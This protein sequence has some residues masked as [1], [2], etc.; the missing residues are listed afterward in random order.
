MLKLDLRRWFGKCMISESREIKM[1]FDPLT[2]CPAGAFICLA[3][4]A[5]ADKIFAAAGGDQAV[6]WQYDICPSSCP[7]WFRP[8]GWGAHDLCQVRAPCVGRGAWRRVW[9][10]LGVP[11]NESLVSQSGVLQERFPQCWGKDSLARH[12]HQLWWRHPGETPS[13]VGE[14]GISRES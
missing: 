1:V 10:T 13:T 12:L 6:R 5:V 8:A 14:I 9:F 4:P 11:A 7:Y 3:C 2:E